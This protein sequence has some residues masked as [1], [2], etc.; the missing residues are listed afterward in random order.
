L[1]AFQLKVSLP[2]PVVLPLLSAVY[3]VLPA[4]VSRSAASYV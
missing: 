2:R 3:V 1:S 4:A